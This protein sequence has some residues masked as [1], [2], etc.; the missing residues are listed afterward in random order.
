MRILN[1]MLGK[2]KG[3][4]EQAALDYHE[5]LLIAGHTPVSVI[6]P[7]SALRES[8][9][10]QGGDTVLLPQHG[11]WDILAAWRL[12]KLAAQHEATLAI[13]HGNRAISLALKA[14]KTRIP[15]IGVAHNYNI[16][17]FPRCDGAFC[18]TR[19]ILEDMVH[20]DM[21]R[22]T[23]FHIPNMVRTG[24]QPPREDFRD[25][26]VIGTMGRFV[27]K[28]GFDIYLHALKAL[29][30]QAIPFRAILGGD[31]ALATRLQ[32]Q[33]AE[34]GI[35][36]KV[37]FTGWV[38]DKQAFFDSLDIFVLPSQ[39]EPFGIVLIEA[40]QQG[41][42]CVTTDSEG[43]C[44]IITHERNAIMVEKARPYQMAQA[45]RALLEEPERARSLGEAAA[46]TV[47][48]TYDIHIVS[49]RLNRAISL[50]T[51]ER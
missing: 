31:G 4:L 29:H 5:A 26:P 40:M 32:S 13:A 14:L 48:E 44:E 16:K 6:H 12:R 50:L 41:L 8:F 21:P 35:A 37:T 25:P 42:P 2:G 34:F 10:E 15:I 39:H 19:D 38:S 22:E 36:D 45:L 47:R 51:T 18:I 20:L 11:E 9:R 3:G 1:I 17:R 49:A 28:K 43:P 7:H 27:E 30:D 33:A 23:L 46:R 24:E